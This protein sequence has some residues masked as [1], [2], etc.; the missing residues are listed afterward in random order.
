MFIFNKL[1]I[2]VFIS[3]FIGNLAMGMNDSSDY[4]LQD[5][6]VEKIDDDFYI[7]RMQSQ[8]GKKLWLVM[9]RI[10]TTN[11]RLWIQYMGAQNNPRAMQFAYACYGQ[12]NGASLKGSLS[13]GSS[14][15]MKVLTEVS[16][17][18]NEVW[19]AYVTKADF[20]IKIAE[21]LGA[22]YSGKN[23]FKKN[24]PF[25]KD[26]EMFVTVT[27]SAQALI[28]SHMGIAST[29]EGV[30]TRQKGTSIDLHSFAA[31]VMLMLNPDRRFMVNA[32]VF[33]M[34]QIILNA[35]PDDTFVGTWQ[36]RERMQTAQ[37]VGLKEFCSLYGEDCRNELRT[38]ANKEAKA[39]NSYLARE[40]DQLHNG[41]RPGASIESLRQ[42]LSDGLPDYSLIELNSEG[43]FMASEMKIN[44]IYEREIENKFRDFKNPCHFP[45]APTPEKMPIEFLAFMEKHPPILSV[46]NR[47][48]FTIYDPKNFRTPWLTIDEANRQTYDWIH[49]DPFLPAGNTHFIA[50]DLL[51]LA[52]SK[53]LMKIEK[54]SR[55]YKALGSPYSV[56][57]RS[58]DFADAEGRFI[59]ELKNNALVV[60]L[61][62]Q[63]NVDSFDTVAY[64]NY[65]RLIREGLQNKPQLKSLTI[66]GNF[67]V[68]LWFNTSRCI[69]DSDTSPQTF[70]QRPHLQFF[71]HLHHLHIQGDVLGS[72]R[73][74]AYFV[75]DFVGH[76]QR[77]KQLK[78]CRVS[79]SR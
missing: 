26:I 53:P 19:A 39:R 40:I 5:F 76:L 21:G 17:R 24:D 11:Q 48:H 6:N 1:F 54:D 8:A 14:H 71:D 51:A 32:P 46:L 22:G 44:S 2:C 3:Y 68:N 30:E 75:I 27:S 69:G 50:V 29:L 78:R 73:N 66:V 13:D 55:F 34:E 36:M 12:K 20:P 63:A 74:H 47:N 67:D 42:Y 49:T 62:I 43:I 45:P 33:A 77:S 37:G 10:T 38:R 79:G 35:L 28:T 65:K 7:G 70:L 64:E 60:D 56:I 61:T 4:N 58:R 18:D 16:L 15:F 57:I 72:E 59:E 31:K 41:K 52:H 23:C 9:E 25:A